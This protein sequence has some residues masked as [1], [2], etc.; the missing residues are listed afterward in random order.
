MGW[1][2][3][4]S[5]WNQ[6]SYT[7]GNLFLHSPQ[8]AGELAL[9]WW[10]EGDFS[11]S[12]GRFSIKTHLRSLDSAILG[13]DSALSKHKCASSAGRKRSLGRE[14]GQTLCSH[15]LLFIPKI[16]SY[17]CQLPPPAAA[18]LPQTQTPALPLVDSDEP[19]SLWEAS[20]G[21]SALSCQ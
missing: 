12:S 6:C 18:A 9:P 19:N 21:F 11:V 7:G 4:W 20:K 10:R 14:F 2:Q 13:L 1:H 15:L 8:G 17:L 3:H 16:F 5:W